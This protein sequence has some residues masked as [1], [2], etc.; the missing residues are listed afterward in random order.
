MTYRVSTG[1]TVTLGQPVSFTTG[2]I[3]TSLSFA[4]LS[5]PLPPGPQADSTEQVVLTDYALAPEFPTATN[6]SA[7]MIWY[8]PQ[9]SSQ[10]MRP[11]PGG[12]MLLIVNGQG[13]GT[14]VWGPDV[15]RAANIARG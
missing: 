2:A 12:T 11:V 9:I 8:Y 5:V 10:L 1:G 3:P 7:G 15:M 14:G 4:A 13:T 6:L